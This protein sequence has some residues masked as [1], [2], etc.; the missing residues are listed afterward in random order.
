LVNFDLQIIH[1]CLFIHV[2]ARTKEK[3][4]KVIVKYLKMLPYLKND[5]ID[6]PCGSFP[7][8][9]VVHR[10]CRT[11]C[12]VPWIISLWWMSYVF[13]VQIV[14]IHVSH[15]SPMWVCIL[16][17]PRLILKVFLQGLVRQ[18]IPMSTQVVFIS[19]TKLDS[20][21]NQI[22]EGYLT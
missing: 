7:F 9:E 21:S 5:G 13:L 10:V 4:I 12:F 20:M 3:L 1:V 14:N 6:S 15:L 2:N 19:V 16:G 8:L 11:L 18:N 17:L 22:K